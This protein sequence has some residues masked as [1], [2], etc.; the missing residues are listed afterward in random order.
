MTLLPLQAKFYGTHLR[1]GDICSLGRIGFH[2]GDKSL[3]DFQA[4]SFAFKEDLSELLQLFQIRLY[5]EKPFPVLECDSQW[6]CG[7]SR[8]QQLILRGNMLALTIDHPCVPF[9]C[10]R[11]LD[12]F[13]KFWIRIAHAFCKLVDRNPGFGRHQNCFHHFS[14][15]LLKSFSK[16]VHPPVI[17]MSI[18]EWLRT[19]RMYYKRHRLSTDSNLD[20]ARKLGAAELMSTIQINPTE[21]WIVHDGS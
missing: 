14:H 10:Q 1:N 13:K 18:S 17:H 5:K 16:H 6:K 20:S 9:N 19:A 3:Y 7:K 2:D 21:D 4:S 11:S 8:K 15:C 12:F